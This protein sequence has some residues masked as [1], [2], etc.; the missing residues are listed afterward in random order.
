MIQ[1]A[2]LAFMGLQEAAAALGIHP[3]NLSQLAKAGE[4]PAAK[5][6]KEWRFLDVDLAAY[7]RARYETSQKNEG[8][9]CRSTREAARGGSTSATTASEFESLLA[10]RTSVKRS[11][12]MTSG[13]PKSGAKNAKVL[14]F[15]TP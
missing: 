8:K 7:L 14:G 1:T 15:P 13:V 2:T 10:P 12:S 11:A 3:D 4:V 5:V 6:G 9:A